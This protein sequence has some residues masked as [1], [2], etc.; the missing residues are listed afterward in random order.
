MVP[1]WASRSMFVL[2]LLL[3][4]FPVRV[5]RRIELGVFATRS[6][7]GGLGRLLFWDAD[8]MGRSAVN[9][10]APVNLSRSDDIE[11]ISIIL[12]DWSERF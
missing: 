6:G 8:L 3:L 11:T 4:S 12:S 10:L 5:L 2:L 9:F 1:R 7:D